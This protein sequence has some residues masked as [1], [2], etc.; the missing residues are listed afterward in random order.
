MKK[1]F[2]RDG[3]L[4]LALL[5]VA[6]LGGWELFRLLNGLLGRQLRHQTLSFS[7]CCLAG[8]GCGAHREKAVDRGTGGGRHFVASL[9]LKLDYIFYTSCYMR[10][11]DT[12]IFDYPMGHLG[13]IGYLY[14]NHHLPDFDTR[15]AWSFSHPPLHACHCGTVG[16]AECEAGRG[17]GAGH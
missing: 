15:T 16:E 1:S 7:V 3:V 5:F 8:V 12:L 4:M 2:E 14:Y 10:Q 17:A 6:V 11:Q 13:Y 9:C